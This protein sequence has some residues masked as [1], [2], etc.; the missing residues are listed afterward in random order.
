MH[1]K[2]QRLKN[3]IFLYFCTHPFLGIFQWQKFFIA[4]YNEKRLF[5]FSE[6]VSHKRTVP[7][8]LFASFFFPW[9]FIF[10]FK[11]K[12]GL[13]ISCIS[14]LYWKWVRGLERVINL[15]K[16]VYLV[17]FLCKLNLYLFILENSWHISHKTLCFTRVES[18]LLVNLNLL[19]WI[20]LQIPPCCQ[21]IFINS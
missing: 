7:K 12:Y 10:S 9:M 11:R 3:R 13:T 16:A 1:R 14:F 17:F 15:Q 20:F 18:S 19:K 6:A 4:A 8:I 2:S 5:F 21:L